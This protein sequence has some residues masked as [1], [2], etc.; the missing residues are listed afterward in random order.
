MKKII[1]FICAAVFT[2]STFAFIGCVHAP[3]VHAKNIKNVILLIGDGMGENHIA[4]T[5]TYFGLKEPNFFAGRNGSVATKSADDEVT[6]SA[7]AATAMATGKK[8]NNSSVAMHE[9]KNLTSISELALAAG[10]KVGVVTTDVLSGA[11]P[12]AFSSHA[13]TRYEAHAITKAQATSGLHLLMGQASTFYDYYKED[14]VRN[15]YDIVES[16]MALQNYAN[17]EKLFAML[18]N[19]RS[20][21]MEGYEEHFQLL[22]M[23]TFAM[24]FLENENGYFLMVESAYIDKFN[25]NN[26]LIPSLCETRSLFDCMSFLYETVGEDTAVILTADHESGGLLKAATA[27]DVSNDLYTTREHTSANVP[28]FI[29]NFTYTFNESPQNTE[30]FYVCKKLLKL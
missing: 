6:D 25:H 8:V 10:K 9:G 1:S 15:G 17:S 7:A 23:L 18:P 24:N 22:E 16:S 30:L 29:K 13:K 21:Y 5:L 26:D 4:N 27:E 28:L 2:F 11:T 3:N 12:A 20:A 14:F 19:I